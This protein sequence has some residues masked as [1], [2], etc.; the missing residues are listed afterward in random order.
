MKLMVI[1]LGQKAVE[2]K[3]NSRFILSE[4]IIS[5]IIADVKLLAFLAIEKFPP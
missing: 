1:K 2:E 3:Q 4:K 5:V